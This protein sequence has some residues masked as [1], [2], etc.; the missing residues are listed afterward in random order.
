MSGGKAVTI[1][2][3]TGARLLLTSGEAAVTVVLSAGARV[4][5]TSVKTVAIAV[6]S[7]ADISVTVLSTV[8]VVSKTGL[9]TAKSYQNAKTQDN[10]H[11]EA[12]K[13]NS[14]WKHPQRI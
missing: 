12:A 9:P 6:S 7:A 8:L 4:L 13:Q 10:I 1:V 5:L 2:L 14:A 11:I 3:P